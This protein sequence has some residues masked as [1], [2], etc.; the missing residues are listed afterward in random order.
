MRERWSLRESVGVYIRERAEACERVHCV[1]GSAGCSRER[2]GAQE[3]ER[4]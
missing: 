3:S 4:A 1:R 2:G